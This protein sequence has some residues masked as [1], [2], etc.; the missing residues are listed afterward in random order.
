[1]KQGLWETAV[2][3]EA[4]TDLAR[5]WQEFIGTGRVPENLAH[6]VRP[7]VFES[8]Q[9]CRADAVDPEMAMFPR[10]SAGDLKAREGDALRLV[11]SL[12]RAMELLKQHVEGGGLL[13]CAVDRH[14]CLVHS[15]GDARLVPFGGESEARGA[16]LREELAGTSAVTL[17]LASGSASQCDGL[18]HYCRQLHP[19]ADAA[20]PV[21]DD[22]A[23]LLGLLA[24]FGRG[25]TIRGEFLLSMARMTV[26][27]ATRARWLRQA[28]DAANRYGQF[29]VDITGTSAEAML[30]VGPRGHIRQINPSAIR[31]LRLD[32]GRMDRPVSQIARFRPPLIASLCTGQPVSGLPMEVSTESGGFRVRAAGR[33]LRG[34]GGQFAGTLCVFHRET[35]LAKA[36]RRE[37]GRAASFTFEA[38]LGA[39]EPILRAKA[40]AEKAAATSVSVLLEGASGT[41]KELF[42]Q[43]IHNES[44]RRDGPFVSVNCAAIPPELIESELF[45]YRDGAFTGAR[46]GGMVG[47]FEAADGGTI[48]LDEV[49]DMPL[50]VQAECLRV[51]ENRTV[52]RVGEHEEIPVDIRVITATNKRLADEI[53]RGKFREDLYYRLSVFRITLPRLSECAS[54]MPGLVEEFIERFNSEMSRSVSG[55]TDEVVETFMGHDWPGNIRELKNAIQ[56][57]VMVDSDGTIGME[58]LP[59]ELRERLVAGTLAADPKDPL[60]DQKQ[61]FEKLSRDLA[62]SAKE[63][64]ERALISAGGSVT[65]AAKALGV[66]RAT[67]YRKMKR[68]GIDRRALLAER[69]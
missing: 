27:A 40:A 24:L 38:I 58:D 66:G 56:H 37:K 31:L 2:N 20:V 22:A 10:V 32:P 29:L 34:P 23:H 33:P 42:A 16:V 39:S 26:A 62:A 3:S 12:E 53:E 59:E 57:A 68:L 21:F 36:A 28:R 7:E 65:E 46:R 8:W 18:E 64:Y 44:D 15:W 43:A 45:G 50:N 17:A 60:L 54:D 4:M 69:G 13:A 49:G 25:E 19:F 48:F 47:K 14:G 5:A 52:V 1:M 63:L 6:A 41:G 35:A 61:S 9:R 55:V 11:D 30:I 67:F 51:L